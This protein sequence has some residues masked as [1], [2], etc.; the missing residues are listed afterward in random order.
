MP[1]IDVKGVGINV[2]SYASAEKGDEGMALKIRT[3]A[4]DMADDK[5]N[6]ENHAYTKWKRAICFNAGYTQGRERFAQVSLRCVC[7]S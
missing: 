7:R 1:K 2:R 3:R 6:L 5:D 4:E